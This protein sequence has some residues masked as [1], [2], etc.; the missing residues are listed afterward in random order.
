[1][2]VFVVGATLSLDVNVNQHD[3]CAVKIHCSVTYD[4]LSF[5]TCNLK[6]NILLTNY[7]TMHYDNFLSFF[8]LVYSPSK[9][10]ESL[11]AMY[12][13]D[14]HRLIARYAARLAADTKNAVGI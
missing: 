14:E 3:W 6:S 7:R 11:N 9:L 5:S 8:F 2:K 1:M 4:N 13:D 10:T 12:V